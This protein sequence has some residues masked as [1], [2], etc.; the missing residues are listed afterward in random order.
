MVNFKDLF[1]YGE[2]VPGYDVRVLNEREARAA[3]A[4][5]FV[6]AFLGLTNGV[7]L[8]TA[9]FSK[10]FVTFFAIDFDAGA[11]FCPK[12]K[13]GVCGCCSKTFCVDTW[14][15]T[16]VAYVLLSGDRFSAKSAQSTCLS[17]L[18]GLT[19]F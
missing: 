15:C 3:A 13:A 8:H 17:D 16:G 4:I 5:L 6:G 18:Y 10:Y 9:V 12:S 14:I 1:A 2:T 11:F 19:L 7:M